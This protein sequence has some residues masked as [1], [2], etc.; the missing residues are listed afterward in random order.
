VK[1][2]MNF[3]M[4]AYIWAYACASGDTELYY[5][6]LLVENVTGYLQGHTKLI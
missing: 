4:Y 2:D 6:V 1:N 3:G 5:S